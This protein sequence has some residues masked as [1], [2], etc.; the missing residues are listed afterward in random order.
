MRWH[1]GDSIDLTEVLRKI[2]RATDDD[3]LTAGDVV[4][5]LE[6]RGYGPLL[7]AT[8]LIIILPTGGIPGVPSITALLIILIAVQMLFGRKSP[9]VPKF[10]RERGIKKEKFESAR[11]KVEPYTKKIDLFLKPRLEQLVSGHGVKII[12]SLCIL[13]ALLIPPLEVVP[14]ASAFPALAI[15]VMSIGLSAKD[16]YVMI[17]GF[18]LTSLGMGIALYYLA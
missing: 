2:H 13:L 1:M 4:N 8:S 7:L 5:A 11:K 3:T 14:L 6:H 12:A 10:L 16:G 15:A 9:W 17:L 18:F